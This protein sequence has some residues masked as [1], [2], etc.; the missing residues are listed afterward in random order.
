M[1][2][3]IS[4]GALHPVD[5]SDIIVNR[6]E[7][8]VIIDHI[9]GHDTYIALNSS[10]Q[11]GK[12]TLLY[13]I[14]SHLHKKGYGVFYID[15]A[16]LND[17]TKAEFYNKIC[18][19][20]R[21]SLRGLIDKA[22]E[23]D[24]SSM[25][26]TDQITFSRYLEQISAHTSGLRKL[27]FM[28]DEI[29]GTPE[30]TSFFPSLRRFFHMGRGLTE[31]RDLYQKIIFILT[32]ALELSR[33]T[34][35][36]NSPL[37]NICDTISL[38]DFTQQQI[39]DLAKK[40]RNCP[41]HFVE[42]MT[43]TVYEWSSGHPYLT[44]RIFALIDNYL[45]SWDKSIDQVNMDV[46]KL[47]N[48]HIITGN[49]SNIA[50]IFSYLENQGYREQVLNILKKEQRKSIRYEKELLSVGVVKRSV[51]RHPERSIEC[52]DWDKTIQRL[53]DKNLLEKSEFRLTEAGQEQVKASLWQ[54]EEPLEPDP[55]EPKIHVGPIG[56]TGRVQQ[57]P[58]L[59]P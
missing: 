31:K 24:L 34:D 14:Q 39:Y 58:E 35:G 25:E 55:S 12:T 23:A 22:A 11:T 1:T 2:S 28:L 6:P 59:F 3:F 53:I 9:E 19:D 57:D 41:S 26:I 49:D 7:L 33:L 43:K 51:N 29:G 42:P 8:G 37:R 20:I 54:K 56:T 36:V 44:M 21:D 15:L 13:Q 48:E 32:G 45:V 30:D 52:P 18:S 27:V 10:R 38:E 50:H 5:H 4:G 16:W 46:N 47:V 40:I 17:L